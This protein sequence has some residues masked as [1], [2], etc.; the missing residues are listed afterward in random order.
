MKMVEYVNHYH[1][2]TDKTVELPNCINLAYIPSN[3]RDWF[4]ALRVSKFKI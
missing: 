1:V 3:K 2:N 4:S